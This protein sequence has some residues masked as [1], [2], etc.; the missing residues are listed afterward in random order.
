MTDEETQEPEAEPV[1]MDPK[2]RL[3]QV[4]DRRGLHCVSD[5]PD[6]ALRGIRPCPSFVADLSPQNA[7]RIL[8]QL[9]W[10][11]EGS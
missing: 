2:I 9:A 5:L 10:Q 6:S 11:D 7:A 8:R 3:Q 1:E 4:L